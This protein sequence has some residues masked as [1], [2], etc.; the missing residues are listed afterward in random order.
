MI[1]SDVPYFVSFYRDEKFLNK[2][3]KRLNKKQNLVKKTVGVHFLMQNTTGF[4]YKIYL[5]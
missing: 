3:C 4:Q 5:F 1:H 2:N